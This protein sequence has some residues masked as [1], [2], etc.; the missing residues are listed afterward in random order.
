MVVYYHSVC[1]MSNIISFLTHKA[2]YPCNLGL[3][4][5]PRIDFNVVAFTFIS[6]FLKIAMKRFNDGNFHI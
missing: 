5:K 2:V 6:D 4:Y 3:A 1:I